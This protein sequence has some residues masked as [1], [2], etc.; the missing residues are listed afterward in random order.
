MSAF[1]V[2]P[3]HINAL[4]TWA[5]QKRRYR[6]SPQSCAGYSINESA[7]TPFVENEQ[8]CAGTLHAANVES[9]NER[10]D[11][12]MKGAGFKF[13]F[14]EKWQE[15]TPVAVLKLCDCFD[16][17]ACEVKNYRATVAAQLIDGIRAHAIR[18]L[19]G[20]DAA[21]WALGE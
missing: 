21:P 1:V 18:S 15:L 4:V 5:A 14:Y 10:Y 19:P 3:D 7:W 12:D 17:Q 11:D 2:S 20:Y 6:N 9:V 16:Y 13:R 8:F